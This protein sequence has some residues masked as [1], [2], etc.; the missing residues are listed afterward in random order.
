LA[1]EGLGLTFRKLCGGTRV[2]LALP[3]AVEMEAET[4]LLFEMPDGIDYSVDRTVLFVSSWRDP[5]HELTYSCD[6]SQEGLGI[7]LPGVGKLDRGGSAS[8]ASAA[9]FSEAGMGGNLYKLYS[10]TRENAG[11]F[12]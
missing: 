11:D 4:Q 12:I 9:M 3:F 8:A 6:F 10:P 2:E 5:Q 1:V 7:E